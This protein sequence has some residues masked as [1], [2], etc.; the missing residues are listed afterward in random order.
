MDRMVQTHGKVILNTWFQQHPR[1]LWTWKSLA[2]NVKNMI[3]YGTVNKRYRNGVKKVNCYPGADCNSDHVVVALWMLVKIRCLRKKSKTPKHDIELLHK[4]K[5]IQ[6]KY[7][8]SVTNKF[9]VLEK[10]E[11]LN[12]CW[13]GIIYCKSLLKRQYR[14]K[15]TK[16]IGS[17]SGGWQCY[18]C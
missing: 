11:D 14:L 6:K 13:E 16:V 10:S 12:A 5:D 7:N 8:V 3:D 15:N 17:G 1:R 18:S 9:E 4:C 2:G